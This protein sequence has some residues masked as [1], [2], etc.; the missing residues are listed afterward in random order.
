MEEHMKAPEQRK[1]QHIL[2]REFVELIH[3]AEEAKDAELRHRMLFSKCDAATIT[4]VG[5]EE[6]KAA[7]ITLNNAPKPHI[8]L[9]VSLIYNKSIGRIVYAAGLAGSS[10]DGHRSIAAGS[11]YIGAKPGQKAAMSDAALTFTPVKN[12][13]K[14]DTRKFLVDGKLM[15]LRKG[16]HNIRII[17]VVPDEEWRESGMKYPGEEIDKN[18]DRQRELTLAKRSASEDIRIRRV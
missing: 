17:E 14:E 3:G 5:K 18:K 13:V 2:A 7:Q 16:K 15:I 8:K 12:W 6:D 1:A 9:P 10:N 4:T 11:I